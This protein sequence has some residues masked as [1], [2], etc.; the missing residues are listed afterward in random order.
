MTFNIGRGASGPAGT[1]PDDIARV[2][3]VIAEGGGVDVACLQ[4]VHAADVPVLVEA[5]GADHGLGYHSYFTA[6]VP[7]DRMR[8]NLERARARRDGRRVAH[9]VGRQSAYGIAVLSRAALV[10]VT[11]HPL[12]DDR[13]EPRL[14]QE[15]ATAVGGAPV[16]ILNTHLGLVTDRTLIELVTF[17]R[18]PQQA[19]T[20][21]FVALVERVDGPVVAAGDLNQGPEMLATAVRGTGLRPVSDARRPT[22]GRRVIDHVLASTGVTASSTEVREAPVSDHDPVVVRLTIPT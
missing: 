5:L 10:K 15:V 17:R 16:T 1:G 14:A 13:R 2:A 18:S 21:A 9:L 6:A 8:A 3:S 7:A 22:C 12:P 19:Q 20:R 11:D 4:E